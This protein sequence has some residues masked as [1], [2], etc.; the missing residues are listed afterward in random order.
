MQKIIP[1]LWYSGTADEAAE[2]YVQSLPQ[3]KL[4]ENVAYPTEGLADF[5]LDLAGKTLTN[6]ISIDGFRMILVNAGDEFRPN[7]AINFFL[8]FDAEA[9]LR[10]T[11]EKLIVGG[12]VLM[13]LNQY[14]HSQL[15]GWV[16]DKYRVNWQLMLTNPDGDP[17][18]F[19]VPQLMFCGPAQN[20]AAEATDYYI[21]TIE[22]SAPGNRVTYQEMGQDAPNG[23]EVVFSD[24]QLGGQWFSAMDSA[25]DQAFTFTEGVSLMVN[26]KDQ[27]EI[28]KYW[29]ALSAVPESEV[30][31]WLKDRWG[32]SWQIV[33]EN[34]GE[35][36]ER[37]GAY[38]KM[39]QMKK[40]IIDE[41]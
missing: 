2:F 29:D 25:V 30:C 16:E 10:A 6:E 8:N 7:P 17:R 35:L 36:M 3:T 32:M 14:P 19:V 41:F 24:F 1:N 20:K 39:M 33:P 23:A 5:Q 18:P 15:Y 37:P 9:T 26:C 38:E 34:M 27:A 13:E 22:D 12:K 21:A 28:D 4:E 31:G 11:W 40:L